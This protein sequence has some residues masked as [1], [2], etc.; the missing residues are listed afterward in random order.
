MNPQPAP[1]LLTR[2]LTIGIA[3][4]LFCRDLDLELR[5]G[6][7][8]ALLGRNG[9]G[10]TTLLHTLAG[11]RAPLSG[12]IQVQGKDLRRLRRRTV[13]RV[14]GLMAQDSTDPF[15][16]TVLATALAGRH[17]HLRSWQWEDAGQIRIALDALRVLGLEDLA[18]RSVQSLSG[19]ERRRLA[20][21]TLLTQDPSLAL[22]DEPVNHLDVQQ[23]MRVLRLLQ[24]RCRRGRSVLMVIHDVNLALRFCSHWMLLFDGGET[25]VGRRE[26]AAQREH[27]ERLYGHP[28]LEVGDGNRTWLFPS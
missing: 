21:A 22:L 10:K 19:G 3:G 27:L 15:P 7:C 1:T 26:D 20:L 8:W 23:Q 14:L 12:E 25:L 18:Q 16:A 28:M 11:L 5:P 17:P 24:D 9:A 13:A 2:R 6:Q 4:R